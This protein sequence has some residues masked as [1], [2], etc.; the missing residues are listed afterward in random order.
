MWDL[1]KIIKRKHPIHYYL[2][3]MATY[4]RFLFS[5]IFMSRKPK[6]K[7]RKTEKAEDAQLVKQLA[8]EPEPTWLTHSPTCNFRNISFQSN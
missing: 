6:K 2:V 5:I 4:S 7:S 1:L 8:N 3:T